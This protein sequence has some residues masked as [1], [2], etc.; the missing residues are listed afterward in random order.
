MVSDGAI[1]DT[2][3]WDDGTGP[4]LYAV[5]FFALQDATGWADGVARWTGT[6]WEPVGG[7]VGYTTHTGY[8]EVHAVDVYN[9]KLIIAGDFTRAGNV[10]AN[11]IATWDG[12]RWAPLGQGFN[13]TST[14]SA[15]TTAARGRHR[16]RRGVVGRRRMVVAGGTTLGGTVSAITVYN[17]ELVVGGSFSAYVG[18]TLIQYLARF[19]GHAW[20]PVGTGV[21]GHGQRVGY[22]QWRADCRRLPSE[23]RR[24]V[25]GQHRALNGANWAPLVAGEG[26]NGPVYALAEYEGALMVGGSFWSAGNVIAGLVCARGMRTVPAPGRDCA[27]ASI[28]RASTTSSSISASSTATSWPRAASPQR[29]P[30]VGARGLGSLGLFHVAQPGADRVRRRSLL[31]SARSLDEFQ[32]QCVERSRRRPPALRVGLRRRVHGDDAVC[33][34]RAIRTPPPGSSR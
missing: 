30:L 34:R 20:S 6:S 12:T 25:R 3:V 11:N 22:L 10:P 23:R 18:G 24:R 15:T 9:G 4:V 14:R 7:G 31:R 27:T 2:A 33:T 28:A 1:Y 21:N 16:L 26:P 5:G 32:W 17:G 8:P 13:E 29:G 19:D